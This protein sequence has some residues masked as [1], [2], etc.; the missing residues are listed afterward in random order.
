MLL[1]SYSDPDVGLYHSPTNCYRSAGWR[2]IEDSKVDVKVPGA[3][4]QRIYLSTWERKG[5][6]ALVAYWFRL[7][8]YT[9][10]ERWNM[11]GVRWAMRGQSSWPPLVKILLQT[12]FVSRDSYH[13]QARVKDMVMHIQQWLNQSNAGEKPEI[14]GK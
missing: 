8:D 10:F 3:A 4:D 9:L 7:G 5:E 14:A 12:P 2:L 1:A 6:T 13:C 11:L